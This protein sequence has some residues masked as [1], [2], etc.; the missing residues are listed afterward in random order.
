LPRAGVR[1]PEVC[2]ALHVPCR[3]GSTSTGP[4]A[5]SAAH[6]RCGTRHCPSRRGVTIATHTGAACASLWLPCSQ[7][8][9]SATTENG[10]AGPSRSP[11]APRPSP[12]PSQRGPHLSCPCAA[13]HGLIWSPSRRQGGAVEEPQSDAM[14]VDSTME[15]RPHAPPTPARPLPRPR[16]SL[17]CSAHSGAESLHVLTPLGLRTPRISTR[18][19]RGRH[20]RTRASGKRNDSRNGGKLRRKSPQGRSSSRPS[21]AQGRCTP[22][23]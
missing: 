4:S 10:L 23:T 1:R 20:S 8:R 11:G 21:T 16:R 17:A 2:A 5:R 19:Q 22:Q 15:A 18:T 12:P 13:H 6:A 3:P 14:D 9:E 7:V